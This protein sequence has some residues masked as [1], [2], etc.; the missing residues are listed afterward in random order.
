MARSALRHGL[1]RVGH[2]H[3][4]RALGV[5][6]HVAAVGGA[7]LGKVLGDVARRGDPREHASEVAEVRR[8]GGFGDGALD[9]TDGLGI[10]PGMEADH[11]ALKQ[12]GSALLLG[13]GQAVEDGGGAREFAGLE[14]HRALRKRTLRTRH[15]AP[16]A[17]RETKGRQHTPRVHRRISW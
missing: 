12:H 17:E 4:V 14:R 6:H 9:Q 15:A 5:A 8:A 16:E 1:E 13:L 3:L 10:G 2:Q 11:A 7:R